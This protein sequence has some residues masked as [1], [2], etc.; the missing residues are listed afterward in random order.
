[1]AVPLEI[2][3]DGYE[4]QWQTN[5][6]AHWVLTYHLLP[7]ILSTAR[8]SQPGDVRIVNVTSMGH[9]FAPK[10]GINFEDTN[11]T[12]SGGI[13][14]RYGQ[15][16]LANILHA[17]YLN[18][19][20]GPNGTHKAEGEIWFAAVHPGNVYTDLNR[21]AKFLGPLSGVVV[22]ALNAVG[23]YIPA[24]QGAYTSVFCAGSEGFKSEMS[25]E[26]FVPLGK[27]AKPSKYARD[28]K[29]AEKLAAWTEKEMGEKG[30]LEEASV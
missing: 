23:T 16:K 29:L 25:G 28:G 14:S 17:K 22:K 8:V 19:L 15:S 13:W 6:L 4:S 7:L 30:Y 2:S 12:V 27:V 18:S 5:Y 3:K 1:M 10:N 24:D 9:S 21:N 26:Y 11:Q 20:Y